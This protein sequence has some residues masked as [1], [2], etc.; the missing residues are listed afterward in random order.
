MDD[1]RYCDNGVIILFQYLSIYNGEI[2]ITMDLTN[3]YDCALKYYI[4]DG[5]QKM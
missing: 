2:I 4:F 3:H 5:I 1:W